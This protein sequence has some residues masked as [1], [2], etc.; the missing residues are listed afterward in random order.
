MPRLDVTDV[1]LDPDF[2]ETLTVLRRAEGV[3]SKGRVTTTETTI[4]PAPVGVVIAQSDQPIQRGPDQQNLP[5]LI[6]IH[7]PFRLRSASK[8]P[9][10]GAVYQPDIIVWGGDRFVVNKTMDFS[11]YGR[12][13]IQADC[14]SQDLIDQ[15]AS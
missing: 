15:A 4:T 1:L 7:T 2:C 3:S 12:G 9:I 6:E 10:S 5:R 8:D 13:F 14:S 11:R